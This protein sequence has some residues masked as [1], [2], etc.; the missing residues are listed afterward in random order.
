MLKDF[1][2]SSKLPPQHEIYE[3]TGQ[4]GVPLLYWMLFGWI[5]MREGGKIRPRLRGSAF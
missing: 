1:L 2:F 4:T 3:R 5:D